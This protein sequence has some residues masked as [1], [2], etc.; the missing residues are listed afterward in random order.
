[1]VFFFVQFGKHK[2]GGWRYSREVYGRLGEEGRWDWAATSAD[3]YGFREWLGENEAGIRRPGVPGGF[4]NHRKYESLNAWGNNGTGATFATYIQW[5]RPPRTHTELFEQTLEEADG[6]PR[7]AFGRLYR[8]M[9][10]I[11]RFGRVARFDY[12]AMVANLGLSDIEP[13]STHL[14]GST[15]P[16]AGARLL[17]GDGENNRQLETLLVELGD[18]LGVTMQVLED[19]L[20]N[21]QKSPNVFVPF[22]G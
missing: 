14:L 22:R 10:G 3:P 15:G 11:A 5:I 13:D 8:S 9:N 17:L 1:M 6:H 12:L 21:W 18:H 16:L 20:C 19:A 4:G 2:T 7:E